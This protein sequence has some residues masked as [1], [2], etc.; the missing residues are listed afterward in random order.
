MRPA[1]IHVRASSA[2]ARSHRSLVRLS[3]PRSTPTLCGAAPTSWD[4][5][6]FDAVRCSD[7]E[8]L[9]WGVCAECRALIRQ[10]RSRP[11][12]ESRP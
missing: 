2:R 8:A 5:S 7:L 3:E 11:I 1:T 9:G 6:L 12:E 10:A 4:W